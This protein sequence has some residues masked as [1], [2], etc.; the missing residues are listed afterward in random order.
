MLTDE[1]KVRT[2]TLGTR[3]FTL[4]PLNLNTLEAIEEEFGGIQQMTDRL[5]KKPIAT[6]K[7]MLFIF[8]KD[9]QPEITPSEIGRLVVY[10]D[11]ERI[12]KELTEG[13]M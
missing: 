5:N 12:T 4:S 9:S 13:L 2:I 8:L 3:S 10:T 6:I 1:P 7:K 11:I